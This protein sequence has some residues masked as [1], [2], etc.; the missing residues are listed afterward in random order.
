MLRP[1]TDPTQ[2]KAPAAGYWRALQKGV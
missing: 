1:Y 2:V